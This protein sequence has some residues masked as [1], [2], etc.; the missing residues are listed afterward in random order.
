MESPAWAPMAT[1]GAG[2]TTTLLTAVS[3]MQNGKITTAIPETSAGTESP[4]KGALKTK[5]WCEM[6]T[7]LSG[8]IMVM[9]GVYMQH[10]QNTKRKT[11]TAASAL[12]VN[13]N[14][15]ASDF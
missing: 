8:L 7:L 13:S 10:E 4:A 12:N 15:N 14:P 5:K 9:T 1:I 11:L 2:A 6:G 3:M